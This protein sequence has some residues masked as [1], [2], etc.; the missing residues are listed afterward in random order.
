MGY[1][2]AGISRFNTADSLTV[3]GD[4]TASGTVLPTGDTAAGDAAAVGFTSA[5]GLILTGQ[6]SSSDLTIKNDADATVFSVPT[7]QQKIL[8]PDNARAMFG[9][10]SD[11]QIYHDGSDSYINDTGTGNLRLAGSSQIDI[12]SS[13][14]EFMAKFIAD[15]AATLYHDNA[16]KINTSSTGAT[17]AGKLD[18]GSVG[19]SGGTA[20]EVAFGGVGG[21]IDG[22][23]IRNT[24]GNYLELSAVSSGNKMVLTNTGNVGIGTASPTVDGSLAGVTV[25]SGSRY[26]HVHDGDSAVLKVSD[27]ATSAN[28]GAQFGIINT[29]AILNNCESGNLLIGQGNAEVARFH[30][31]G[32]VGIGTTTANYTTTQGFVVVP[33]SNGYIANGHASG[34]ANGT[35]YQLFSLAGTAIGSVSQASSSS[36]AYNTTSDYRRKTAVSYDW[37]ATTRLKQLKPCRFKWISEGDTAPFV[38]G[39]LAHEVSDTVPEAITGEKDAMKDEEYVVTEAK[40]DIYTPATDDAD[41]VIHSSDVERPMSLADGRAWRETAPQ[42]TSTRNVPDYQQIDQSKLVPLLVKTIQE[43]EARIAT[44]E[45]GE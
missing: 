31:G 12:I 29:T 44:L 1:I 15:G 32:V 17:I 8:F 24:E 30:Q 40:G 21:S 11:L 41:E 4:V 27:P 34:T 9:D 16:A 28:R 35:S 39:F 43:L 37:D 10:G 6:G 5:E 45:A 33:A 42:V 2:G 22:F 14:G 19:A 18:V 3:T 36:V 25:P 38:D 26:L 20:G 13:G 23:R 7:G